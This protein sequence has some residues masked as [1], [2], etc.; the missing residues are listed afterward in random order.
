MNDELKN[1]GFLM[2]RSADII[3]HFKYKDRELL[4]YY[5]ESVNTIL[6]CEVVDKLKDGEGVLFII[7]ASYN[8]R[9]ENDDKIVKMN[10]HKNNC[11][12]PKEEIEKFVEDLVYE[13]MD[14]FSDY[15]D[16][17]IKNKENIDVLQDNNS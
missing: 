12:F 1:V 6:L 13:Y 15:Y 5:N 8:I 3:D 17:Y 10:I 2:L 14:K 16:K 9:E 4:L 11:S 7:I